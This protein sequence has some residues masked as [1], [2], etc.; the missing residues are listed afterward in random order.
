MRGTSRLRR[1]G[2]ATAGSS[3]MSSAAPTPGAAANWSRP[4]SA[5]LQL[6]AGAPDDRP[7]RGAGHRHPQRRFPAPA[8]VLH[9]AL[10]PDRPSPARPPLRRPPGVP[11]GQ[12][13][14]V[15][16][17]PRGRPFHPQDGRNRSRTVHVVDYHHVIHAL[18]RK[19]NALLNLAYRDQLFPRDAYRR[20]WDQAGG[21]PASKDQPAGSWSGCWRWPMN[22]ACETDLA[23]RAGPADR[24]GCLAR[25]RC[26][27]KPLCPRAWPASRASP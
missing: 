2:R 13:A 8:G 23:C 20:T 21:G 26:P 7:R 14:M 9:R 17:L 1:A 27:G 3:T 19:P 12:P 4:S 15:L 22:A 24:G 18:R 11:A 10:P 16:T 5:V 25:S 6:P